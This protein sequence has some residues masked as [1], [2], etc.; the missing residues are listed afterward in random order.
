[1]ERFGRWLWRRY[2]HRFGPA[3]FTSAFAI[4]FA[5]VCYPP[6]VAVLILFELSA[7]DSLM[8]VTV[9]AGFTILGGALIFPIVVRHQLASIRAWA[10]GDRSDPDAVRLAAY[11]VQWAIPRGQLIMFV[12]FV[13]VMLPLWL[14]V[15]DLGTVGVLA[16]LL[17]IVQIMVAGGITLVITADLLLRPIREELDSEFPSAPPVRQRP[18]GLRVQF[19]VAALAMTAA[20]ITG[21][22][23]AWAEDRETQLLLV[24]VLA[25]AT[26]AVHGSLLARGLVLTPVLRPVRDLLEGTSRVTSGDYT[27][28]IPVT[29]DDDLGQL[30]VSFNRMQQG[31]RERERLHAA[32]G[33]YV[34]PELAERLLGQRDALFEGEEAE[35]SIFFVDVRNFTAFSERSGARAT[36]V[37]LDEL[38]GLTIPAVRKHGGHVNGF[39]G[40]GLLAVFGAPGPMRDHADR[41]V[42]A[43]CEIER[44]VCERFA[45]EVRIGIGINTGSVVAGTVGG[46]GRLEF[47]LIGDAV[48][49]ASRVEQLTKETGDT[50]LLTQATADALGGRSRGSLI[51]RGPHLVKG[52]TQPLTV[53]TL[54]A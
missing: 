40:D 1:M 36:M 11:T 46:G 39:R 52:R 17:G 49:V 12:P 7:A 42:A 21:A 19:G 27:Q 37:R 18:A 23:V 16:T 29:S 33:A 54:I 2:K 50:I 14:G 47:T 26:A 20:T 35:V 9:A 24:F 38:F 8:L 6:A 31:L 3:L 43:A 48:N 41:A 13:A 10:L 53:Y 32:F 25:G 44:A 28:R 45:G 34:D 4:F 15:T 51:E 30:V 22:V 5:V